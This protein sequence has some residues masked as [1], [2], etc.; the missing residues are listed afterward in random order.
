[1]I[2]SLSS[3][4]PLSRSFSILFYPL[5]SYFYQS[6][7][8]LSSPLTHFMTSFP[9]LIFSLLFSSYSMPSLSYPLFFSSPLILF[10]VVPLLSSFLLVLS[11]YSIL[12]YVIPLL[13]SFLLL[14]FY[15]TLCHSS[16]IL[17]SP[18]L[19]LFY[20][21]LFYVIPLLFFSP[22]MSPSLIPWKGIWLLVGDG[23]KGP[24]ARRPVEVRT[25]VVPSA[26]FLDEHLST[27]QFL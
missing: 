27:Y 24:N 6:S 17:F 4:P 9:F 3:L 7:L 16:P 15:L 11:F 14:F 2:T 10:Y 19:L 8:F 23:Y 20:S 22:S 21:I 18:L 12:F 25:C 1:M 13:S 5:L 26:Y